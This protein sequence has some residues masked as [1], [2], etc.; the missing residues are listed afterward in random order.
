MNQD[1]FIEIDYEKSLKRFKDLG[2]EY[3]REGRKIFINA[4]DDLIKSAIFLLGF[5]GLWFSFKLNKNNS[6]KW[7]FIFGIMSVVASLLFGLW[8]K[9]ESNKFFNKWGDLFFIKHQ[10][11]YHYMKDTGKRS[12]EE[13]PEHLWMSEEEKLNDSFFPWQTKLQI[14]LLGIGIFLLTLI[15]LKISLDF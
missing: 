4:S 8:S 9:L 2:D 13:L 1:K 11:L 7:L 3:Y 6:L 14:Y 5:V 10:K 12:G 15:F